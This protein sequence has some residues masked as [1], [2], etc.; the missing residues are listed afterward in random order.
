MP[1]RETPDRLSR[2]LGSRIAELREQAGLTAEELAHAAHLGKGHLSD[3]E[4]GLTRP[5][6]K[7]LQAIADALHVKLLD[8]VTFPEE[9]DRQRL[10][11]RTRALPPGEIARLLRATQTQR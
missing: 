8:L 7:T 4:H 5:T 6:V 9:G 10:V 3:T 1:R 2:R 11:E